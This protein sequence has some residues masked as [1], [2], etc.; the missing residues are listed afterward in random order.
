MSRQ[1]FSIFIWIS[2][3]GSAVAVIALLL[4]PNALTDRLVSYQIS[5]IAQR[6]VALDG[7]R[8]QSASLEALIIFVKRADLGNVPRE[9]AAN[10]EQFFKDVKFG[11]RFILEESRW[12]LMPR[13]GGL[14]VRLLAGRIGDA[15]VQGGLFLKDGRTEKLLTR[16]RVPA[17]SLQP[18]SRL[19]DSRF[20]QSRDGHRVAKLSSSGGRWVLWGSRG[21]VLEA[22]WQ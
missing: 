16:I 11:E 1:G 9:K 20:P 22:R 6:P 21:P 10:L 5:R 17:G 7:V 14:S 8:M 3:A 18:F 19:I 15:S 13:R 2:L 12:M 4:I